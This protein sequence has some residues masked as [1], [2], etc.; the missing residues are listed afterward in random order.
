[1]KFKVGD[2]VEAADWASRWTGLALVTGFDG[3]GDPELFFLR[4]RWSS[5]DY[6]HEYRLARKKVQSE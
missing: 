5:F 4:A 6:A 3:D 2:L 1:M